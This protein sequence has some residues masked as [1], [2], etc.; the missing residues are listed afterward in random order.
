MATITMKVEGMT[1]N[2]CV[3][4]VSTALNG[5]PEV[6]DVAVDLVPGGAS[7]VTAQVTADIPDA[8]LDELI[9]DEGYRLVSVER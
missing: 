7:T 4:H 8:T 1:C 3:H 2:H 6:A 5:R 9:D